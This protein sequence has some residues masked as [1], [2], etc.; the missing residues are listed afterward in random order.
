MFIANKA[1]TDQQ[2]ARARWSH[3]KLRLSWVLHRR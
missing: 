3:A 2:P 1:A